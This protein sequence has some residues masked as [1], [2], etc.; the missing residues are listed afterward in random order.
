MVSSEPP[1]SVAE[2]WEYGLRDGLFT[3]CKTGDVDGLLRLLHPP[4][5]PGV[6]VGVEGGTSEVER[7]TSEVERG[8][9]ELPS[10][11]ALVNK[12][13]DASGFTLLHVSSA[14]GQRAVVQVLMDAGADPACR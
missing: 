13:L 10:A 9:S 11:L 1:D 8:T 2:S 6:E 7:G 4:G 3:A 12:P 5:Q 14:A